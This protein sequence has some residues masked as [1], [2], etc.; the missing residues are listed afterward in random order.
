MIDAGVHGNP[1]HPRRE[2]RILTEPV[3]GPIHLDEDFL[4]DVFGVVVVPRELVRDAIHHGPVPLDERLERGVV[5]RRRA[6]DQFR[7][8]RRHKALNVIDMTQRGG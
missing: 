2:L 8:G 6:C 1:V 3:Q 4:R 7:V 5:P